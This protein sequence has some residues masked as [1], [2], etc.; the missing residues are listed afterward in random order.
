MSSAMEEHRNRPL[1]RN[2]VKTLAL[3]ALRG[4]LELPS[5]RRCLPDLGVAFELDR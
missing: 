4:A 5:C 1:N 2:D 3:A